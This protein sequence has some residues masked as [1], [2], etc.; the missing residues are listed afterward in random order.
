VSAAPESR[1]PCAAGRTAAF[2]GR[3]TEPCPSQARHS[4]GSPNAEPIWLCDEHF[5]QV[6][7][8]GL[9]KEQN[10]GEAEYQ[11]RETKR[12]ASSQPRHWFARRA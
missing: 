3:W 12:R 10:I 4:V 5:A 9:V 11:R 1:P 6:S 2:G 8:A 7:G